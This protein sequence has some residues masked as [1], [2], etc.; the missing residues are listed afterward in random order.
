[1]QLIHMKKFALVLLCSLVTIVAM[2]QP[3]ATL[4]SMARSELSKRGLTEE[5]VRTRL[6]QEGIDVDSIPPSEYKN[7][8]GRVID[9]LN[10]MQKEKN[11]GESGTS[12]PADSLD[13][14]TQAFPV[15]NPPISRNGKMKQTTRDE[16]NAEKSR[17]KMMEEMQAA[18][19]D[20]NSIYGHSF[21]SGSTMDF[22][23]TTDGAQAP[24]TYILGEGDEVHISIFGSSQTEIHQ[25]ISPDGSIQPAG[26]TK[27]FL[28]GL[29][30]AQ[31]RAAVKSKLA[32]HYSFRQ[33]QIAVTISTARTLNVNIYGEVG[34]QGGFTISALNTVFNA[35]TAAGG[36][37]ENGS[38][39]NIQLSRGGKTRKLDLYEFMKNPTDGSYYDLQNN[40]VIFVPLAQKVVTIKGAVKRPMRYE[41]VEGES[42]IDLIEL[43]GGLSDD[44]YT[45]YMQIDR[46]KDGKPELLEFNLAKILENKQTVY[47][48]PSDTVTI[49]RANT[50][51]E[52]YVEIEGDVYYNGRYNLENNRSLKTLLENAKPRYT[53]R[54][55][56]VFVDR[57][58]PDET[59]TVLTV[60]FPGEHGNPDF[61]LE[62]R[63]LVTV[64]QLSQYRDV[65]TIA[66]SGQVRRPFS[67]GFGL[68]DRMTVSQAIEYAG[69]VKQTVYPVAYIFRRDVTNP[70]KMQYLPINLDKDG[71]TLLQPGDSLN[72]YDNTTYTDI[73]EVRISGA[74]KDPMKVSF[75]ENLTIHDMITMAGGFTIGAAY[76]R[77]EVFRVDISKNDEVKFRVITLAVDENYYPL[78]EFQ[79]QPYDHIVVRQ[80]PNFSR[81]R[82]VELN[83]RVK[84]P[85]VY[86]LEDGRTKLSEILKMAG[87]TLDDY[88]PYARLFRTYKGRGNI[89]VDISKVKHSP[90]G[91]I[92]YDPILMSGDVIN[93]V[94]RENTVTIRELGTRMGQYVP[95]EFSATQ[96]TI[97]YQGRR[98]AKWYIKHYAGGFVRDADRN[99]VVVTKPNNDSEGTGHFLW[100]RIYPK[101]EPGSVI[102]V[103]IDYRKREKLEKP[104]E[105]VDWERIAAST[106]SALTSITSM[107][108]LIERLN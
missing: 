59:V 32:Q 1:M 21:F 20:T 35:L 75:D 2:A 31:G 97:I 108:L 28:K 54:T 56:Y 73:G 49:R 16:E 85:G 11:G 53:A 19:V 25:R 94:R 64:L 57:T 88:E 52:N 29:T 74:V 95:D 51:L 58:R 3:S 93:I 69:G 55:D 27:I 40:D 62:A 91:S 68:D 66:V 81:G 77:V 102:T 38:V 22:F 46:I 65:D 4:L 87:G 96:K 92:E 78:K 47:L 9:I 26:S 30:L 106:L 67:R 43:A 61:R 80:T 7:Y 8:Q 41:L 14:G 48:A 45:E 84:Y 6:M 89:G 101:V 42:L 105:K 63:D 107:I 83:G 5:E 36:I 34:V 60:P 44:A 17:K 12:S 79:I 50:P 71:D 100:W 15:K 90:K 99:S 98:S 23:R 37:S 70:E 76:D 86:V 33:D 18:P 39:R 103:N 72:I 104:K 82:T 10:A 24:D 13:N